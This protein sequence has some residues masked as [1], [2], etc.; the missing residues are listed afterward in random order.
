MSH[1][2]LFIKGDKTYTINFEKDPDVSKIIYF[3]DVTF[4]T[5]L[6]HSCEGGKRNYLQKDR[7]TDATSATTLWQAYAGR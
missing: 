5:L 4:S 6:G 2:V 1:C 7:T 3:Q